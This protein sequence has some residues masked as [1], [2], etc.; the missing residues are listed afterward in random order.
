VFAACA[1]VGAP[2]VRLGFFAYDAELGYARCLER[3]RQGITDLTR[4]GA[5]YGL[6]LALQLH[7]RTI[8]PSAAHAL[9]LAEGFDDLW[10]FAD[11]GNQTMEGYED[12][13]LTLDQ[14][15]DRIGCVGVKN[16]GWSLTPAGWQCGWQPLTEVGVVRWPETLAELR[17]RGYD[18]PLSLHAHYPSDDPVTTVGA[19][20]RHLRDLVG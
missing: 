9:R 2:L 19:D 6:R 14:L 16:S 3:A 4:L 10:F 8:H 15:G 17:R 18:G 1:E 12:L 5:R 20:L 13:R 11:P 7:H